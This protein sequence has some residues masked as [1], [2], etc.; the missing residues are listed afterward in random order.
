MLALETILRR[1]GPVRRAGPAGGVKA[2]GG[3]GVLVPERGGVRLCTV[4][5]TDS[6]RAVL[7]AGVYTLGES[8]A[9]V[10][11]DGAK[12]ASGVVCVDGMFFASK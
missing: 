7:L 2:V 9:G 11:M 10:A 8:V 6:G 4:G 12:R 1:R 5:H 3:R